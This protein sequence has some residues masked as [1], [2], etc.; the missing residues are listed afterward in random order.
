M[1]KEFVKRAVMV[2]LCMGLVFAVVLCVYFKV[3]IEKFIP[4]E[5]NAQYAYHDENILADDDDDAKKQSKAEKRKII[6]EK[7]DYKEDKN[8]DPS[9]FTKNQCVGVIRAGAGYG[10]RYDMDY[11]KIQSSVSYLPQSVPFGETG[12]TYIYSGNKV[13]KEIAKEKNLAIGSVFGEKHYVFKNEKS[14]KNEY[15]VLN[16][17]PECRSAVIIYYRESV[18]SGFTSNYIVMVYEEVES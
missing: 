14:F 10:I 13:A 9:T 6:T 16:Y 11:S 12:F 15:S 3:N 8:A 1:D 7:I 4:L 18:S 5:N 2:P 17:A